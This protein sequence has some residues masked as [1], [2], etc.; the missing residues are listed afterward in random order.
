MIAE[1][2]PDAGVEERL[3]AVIAEYL[4]SVERGEPA[5][6]RE[7]V[8][9]YPDLATELELFFA[10]ETR[11]DRLVAPLRSAPV[12]SDVA[13]KPAPPSEQLLRTVK[14]YDLLAEIDRGGMGVI[15]KARQRSLNRLVAVKMI[16]SA[17]WATP[18]E[19][20]RFRW[21]AEAV[22]ALDHPNIV[23]I[24]EIG[25]VPSDDGTQL[26]FFSMKLI[27]GDNLARAR[28]RFHN[29]WKAIAGL[30]IIVA[31][32]VE[33]AHQRGI[34]HRDLKPANILLENP[35]EAGGNGKESS[36]SGVV[37]GPSRV[38]P[39]VSDFGLA[40][41]AQQRGQTLAG[42]I[43]GTPSYLAPELASGEAAATIASDVYSLGAI[44]YELLTGSPPFRAETP[45]ET[46]RLLTT[47]S[48]KAPRK[49]NPAIPFDLETICLKCLQPDA[50]KRYRSAG[51][52]AEDM[53]LFL[54]GRSISARPTG[55]FEAFRRWCRRQPVIAGL[56][57][58]L[59]LSVA[60]SL[61]L[62][63][64][65]WRRAVD[66][67]RLAQTRLEEAKTERERA[68]GGFELAHGAFD[69]LFR[70]IGDN[71]ME[72]S[73]G[74]EALN[75]E[76]LERG[77]RYYREFVDR[78]R[79]DPKMRRELAAAMFRIGLI[80]SRIGTSRE[81]ADAYDKAIVFLRS[82]LEQY[83]DDL[84]LLNL[85]GNSLTNYGHA[86]GHLNRPDE[87]M[88]CYEEAAELY[89]DLP[90]HGGDKLVAERKQASAWMHRGLAA[91]AMQQDWNEALNSAKRSK[92]V[93]A[94]VPVPPTELAPL[95][96]CL[97]NIAIA[98]DNLN[99]LD[100][101]LSSAREAQ[102]TAQRMLA[103]APNSELA[104][105]YVG[106][107][108]RTTGK[109][110][111]R[112]G[113]FPAAKQCLEAAQKRLEG[114]RRLK[115]RV[116]QYQRTVA[117]IYD[118]L[119]ALA[120]R[121]KKPAEAMMYLER[122]LPLFRALIEKEA[123]SLAEHAGLAESARRYGQACY[124]T[125]NFE[126]ACSSFDEARTQIRY[127]LD[128]PFPGPELQSKLALNCFKLALCL[129]NLKRFKEAVAAVDEAIEQY[130]DILVRT[131][132]DAA[133][134][135]ILSSSLGNR[136][137][138]LRRLNRWAEAL[139]ATEDRVNLWPNNPVELYDAAGDFVRTY[140]SVPETGDGNPELRSSAVKLAV[141]ALRQAL[142]A[143][144]AERDKIANDP[145]FSKI[146]E[147]NEFRMFLKEQMLE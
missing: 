49:L 94:A 134:R 50:Q 39:Y 25:E 16:R 102:E 103:A 127:L 143:G 91:R 135:K 105:F 45:L 10:A 38:V 76:L 88:R 53:E 57:G 111:I 92:T 37:V 109:L 36:S 79:D 74:A 110:E 13:S 51:K 46:I 6:P 61:P 11:F 106:E 8:Q 129:N 97:L 55:T 87:A 23:P 131:P 15:F 141:A 12:G 29:E 33:H 35:L 115:P 85:L 137:I 90:A 27:E 98:E 20:F 48:V 24:Y 107:S 121:E 44:L 31:R 112:K 21:E 73:P 116:A 68:D 122:A 126:L 95:I 64:L 14:D 101:A 147:T 60:I 144:F 145:W 114:L 77:L 30:M 72:A 86:L 80:T 26:P 75:K 118:D 22:A 78:R 142:S 108:L 43:V 100:E 66:Q 133:N 71:R 34:L 139:R 52:L 1:R 2:F 41:R 62:I 119:A 84:A 63:L 140:G 125:K 28:D 83:P 138:Y 5:S 96:A 123:E 17:E 82:T 54:A 104:E 93:L 99:H 18:A 4:E 117:R 9:R 124:D 19:R 89:K 59:L 81:T 113:D 40:A 67:E 3:D 42:T 58:A 7:W 70:M 136:A 120:E 130:R 65:N 47:T 128:Q 69:D 32:V 146:R 56:T 132:A